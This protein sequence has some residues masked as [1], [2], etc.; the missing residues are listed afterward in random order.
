MGLSTDI[1]CV[2]HSLRTLDNQK[3]VMMQ[4]SPHLEI[5]LGK[6]EENSRRIVDKCL[7]RDIE[8]LGVTKGFSAL[9]RIVKAMIKGGIQEL[10]DARLENVI[11]LRQQHFSQ[12]MT[13]LRIP[14]LS[15]VEEVI[16]FTDYSINSE[17]TVV[18]AISDKAS[19]RG[20][21]HN[22]ILMIDVGDL[23]EGVLPEDAAALAEKIVRLPGV[24]LCGIGTNMGCYGGVL[25]SIDNLNLLLD[26]K[27]EIENKVG[28]HLK[29]VS[30][31]GT[32]SLKLVDNGMMPPGI[33][34]LR[35]GEGILLGTDTTHDAVIPWLHQDAFLLRTEVIE[36]K[37][38]PSIPIGVTGQDSS[39]NKPVFIDR[40]LR[41]R[42]IVALGKQDVNIEGLIPVDENIHILG[43][44]SDH[45]IV[46]VDDAGDR[47]N[48]GDQVTFRLN[49]QGLLS[50][51]SSKYIKKVYI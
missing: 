22:I 2:N 40:G 11:A 45:L 18:R 28:I 5:N 34:Q 41:K 13:L 42:A 46:D 17:L 12:N 19:E 24:T 14:R 10:A 20:I 15:A 38:K 32:S 30:G 9:P 16:T 31:G 7:Q 44:S 29:M 33:N 21:N 51:G 6:L 48:V 36:M 39:G 4:L 50:S 49:Y 1:L 23:R 47:I 3:E 43:G 27:N 35:I 8:V 25:P 26:V 37:I